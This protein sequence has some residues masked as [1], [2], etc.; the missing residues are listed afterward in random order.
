MRNEMET[1]QR[2]LYNEEN[3]YYTK[4]EMRCAKDVA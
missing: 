1:R 3:T 4:S 2:K